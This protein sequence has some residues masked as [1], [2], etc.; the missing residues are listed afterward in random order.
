MA[1]SLAKPPTNITIQFYPNFISSYGLEY[2]DCISLESHL[3]K[4]V[5]P[6][7]ETVSD[8]EDA[9]L[10]IW[11]VWSIIPRSILSRDSNTD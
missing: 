3:N 10:D 5:C 4:K 6:M 1:F 2:A 11:G 9:V 7:Y 8:G